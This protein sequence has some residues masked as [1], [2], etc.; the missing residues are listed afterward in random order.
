MCGIAG[1]VNF[2]KSNSI[3]KDLI[4]K[5]TTKVSHRGPDHLGVYVDST[6]AFGHSRLSII[7]LNE[8]AN[9]PMS[10]SAQEIFVTYNGEI[11]NFQQIR[12]ELKNKG[13][14][15]KTHSD[16]EV[17][18]YAYKEWGIKCIEK[19]DGM[20]AF[21]LL[22]KKKK[23]F[24]LVRD[25]FGVK[26]VY[27]FQNN[28]D[29]VFCSEIKGILEFPSY[30]KEI[31][32]KAVSDFL[33]FRQTI[34]PET[35]FK[36]VFLLQ[37]ASYLKLTENSSNISEY[38]NLDSCKKSACKKQHPSEIKS[39]IQNSIA[40]TLV[41]D[42]PIVAYLS[43]GLD[44]SIIALEAGKK[45]ALPTL[46]IN[47]EEE[48]YSEAK[49][50][51][52]VSN[53]LGLENQLINIS[54]ESY[55][56]NIRELIRYKDQPL[57]MH[58]EVALYLLAKEAKKQAKVALS[59]EGSDE[60]FG[61]YG[62]IFR[63]PLEF[64]KTHP[65]AFLKGHKKRNTAFFDYFLHSY[66]YFPLE[67]KMEI[68]N[69]NMKAAA[70]F[71]KKSLGELRTLFESSP[72]KSDHFKILH[73]F[74][75]FHLH[76]LLTMMDSTSMATGLEVRFPFV[77]HHLVEKVFPLPFRYKIKW[78]SLFAFL[79]AIFQ[80]PTEY[81]ERKD[82]TKALLKSLYT[83]DLPTSIIHRKKMVFPVPLKEWFGGEFIEETERLLFGKNS[84]CS[85]IFDT[86]KLRNWLAK[87]E[88]EDDP[89]YG[90]KIWLILNLELWLR[91]YFPQYTDNEPEEKN[92]SECLHDKA[93]RSH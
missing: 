70:Q 81:S 55:L 37:P 35:L 27:Y 58:N 66:S 26:P 93:L 39:L 84:H 85:L 73:F 78:N 29:L 60:L 62:R 63:L 14:V 74:Q 48:E 20:F 86:N 54:R 56:K 10:D 72:I 83:S 64:Y 69:E 75:K 19:F 42:V 30:K 16:T 3:S 21:G 12:K 91:E 50:A 65:L 40:K 7:D 79:Q 88:Q 59:G 47:F 41:A 77:D 80:K 52:L 68:F 36:E 44:S 92:E 9:Q 71:D 53:H 45:S 25:R 24:Y 22:D 57:G 32:L 31:N 17:I 34:P 90:R 5:I 28:D 51:K 11:Y 6:F 2:K 61:G 67:E 8:V 43:G 38:W 46:T 89:L 18:I 49:Y 82:Q 76:G 4:E 15:F 13:V 87:K 1:V 23:E 33:S